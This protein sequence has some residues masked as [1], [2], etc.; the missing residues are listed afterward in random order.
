[1]PIFTAECGSFTWPSRSMKSSW[2]TRGFWQSTLMIAGSTGLCCD[3]LMN[4]SNAVCSERG[5][6]GR[7]QLKE[8]HC[9]SGERQ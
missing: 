6:A 3:S 7:E 5:P 4:A 2:T 1:M 9:R 8:K